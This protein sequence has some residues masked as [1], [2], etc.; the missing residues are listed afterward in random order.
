MFKEKYVFEKKD[1][2]KSINARRKYKIDEFA[3]KCVETTSEWSEFWINDRINPRRPFHIPN[4]YKIFLARYLL[5]V[6][7]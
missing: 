7:I 3:K 5:F 1:L 2:I 4:F 6:L